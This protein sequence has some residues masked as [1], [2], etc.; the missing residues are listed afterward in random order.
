[1]A[2]I[3][4]AMYTSKV[5]ARS[6]LQYLVYLAYAL[7]I[8]WTLYAHARSASFAPTFGNIFS[9]GFQCFIIVTLVMVVYTG[10]FS[11]THPELA[12]TSAEFYRQEL[13][14]EGNKLPNEIEEQVAGVKK[15]YT[16]SRVSEATFGYLMLG[17]FF[18]AAG[19]AALLIRRK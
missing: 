8:I 19:T 2:V 3:V 7:G 18:T 11:A 6:S 14:K 17:A 5:P 10:V 12:E 13:V 9:K 4:M 16:V 15:Y 1:M